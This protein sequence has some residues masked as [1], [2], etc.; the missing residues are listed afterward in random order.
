MERNTF[1]M[2]WGYYLSVEKMMKNTS[3]YVAPT[4]QNINT[5]SDE[6]MKIILLSCSEIDSILKVICR[7]NRVILDDKKYNMSVYANTLLKQKD[8]KKWAFS[9]ECSTSSYDS[10]IIC[11]PFKELD[12]GKPYAGLTWWE[13]YQK[14]KHD[15]LGNAQV[16]SLENAV[17]ALTAHFVL[18]RMLMD[19]LT[20]D[21]GQKY[22]KEKYWS[23][24]LTICV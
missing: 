14:L 19:L 15:R 11:F 12:A 9:P 6:F 2:Y 22:V 23:E 3:Q 1:E 20:E 7:E 24:Y 10:G 13:G 8:I 21:M 4:K 17:Y 16:G 5:Y 18:L